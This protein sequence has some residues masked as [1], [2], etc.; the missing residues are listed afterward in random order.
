MSTSESVRPAGRAFLPPFLRRPYVGGFLSVV[1]SG[2]LIYSSFEAFKG[3]LM[4]PMQHLLGISG[5]QYGILMGYIGISVF[6]YVPAGWLLNRIQV[7]TLI[8]VSLAW[9]L[10]TYL[11]I[12]LTTPSFPVLAI[13]AIS[14]GILDSFFW[15]SVVNGV[16]L[17]TRA[18]GEQRSGL[19]MGLLES[20]RRFLEFVMNA[21]VIG[22]IAIFP[23][24]TDR[25]LQIACLVYALVI[26]P[27]AYFVW[28]TVPN[29]PTAHIK[30]TSNSAAALRGLLQVLARPRVW[31]A[32]L[33]ALALYW[34]YINL[35][36]CSAPYLQQVFHV[37]E[38]VA[39][40]FGIIN[41]GLVG[42]I[43]GVISG[44]IADYVFRSSTRM[45]A[46]ALTV[47]AAT[48]IVIV[49]VPADVLSLPVAITLLLVSAFATFFGKAVILAPIAE[50][51]LPEGISG[52]AMAVGS[53]L[54]F[55]SVFWA[56]PL[57]GSIIDAYSTNPAAGYRTIFVITIVVASIGALC[58][59]TLGILN[60]RI[61]AKSH[62][63]ESTDAA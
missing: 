32:G 55:A 48:A 17:I 50:L 62:T 5:E 40:T 63:R 6:F 23:G 11:L 27:N 47:G 37:S 14:W 22:A 8:L 41:T 10:A 25:V 45:L 1:L 24:Q 46:A 12:F 43:S 35:I 29:T 61:T 7:R 33:A 3:S 53:F 15:P 18:S 59:I 2:Q 42:I 49:I 38:S 54:A 31:L 26:I 36:Y 51:Q 9:R 44:V 28:K 4:L 13:V 60:A 16:S 56:Y 57:N 30:G 20:I 21:I 34:S 39:A 52:S 58:A 19:A